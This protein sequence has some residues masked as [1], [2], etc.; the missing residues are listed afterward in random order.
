MKRM[1]QTEW[2]G[3]SFESF[4]PVSAEKLADASFYSA[5][6]AAFF[7][8]YKRLE[9]LD[10]SWVSLKMQMK[11]FLKQDPAFKKDRY[12]L[13]IGCGL[14]FVE[15]T[16]FEEGFK[17]LEVTEVSKEPMMWLL[18]FFPAD[19]AHIGFFP[20]CLPTRRL[21]DYIYLAGV[22]TF[23]TQAE[24]IEFLKTVAERLSPGGRCM[25][26]SWSFMPAG[27]VPRI[28][29][30]CKV[31]IR[32]L[33]DKFGL[34]K[35]GQFWGYIRERRE[36][37]QALTSAGFMNI[38]EGFLKKKTHWDTYWIAADKLP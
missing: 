38:R 18:P 1:Y 23:F 30:D 37:H 31:G 11:E 3:I 12:I 14:G 32:F 28:A 4:T 25:I 36:F 34:K 22:E 20:G 19:Q 10:P 26:I 7:R 35:R 16:L 13:S 21:Y 29:V 24:L 2:H 5:F 8:K 17:R 6:Y 27:L 9:D 33:L 15:K